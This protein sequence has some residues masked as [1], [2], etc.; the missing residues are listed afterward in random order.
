MVNH[1]SRPTGNPSPIHLSGTPLYLTNWVS[2]G[3]VGVILRTGNQDLVVDLPPPA[4]TTAPAAVPE[5]GSLALL[6]VGLV[7]LAGVRRR[8]RRG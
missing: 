8:T 2:S 7:M 1:T 3:D 4:R 6:G 5:P